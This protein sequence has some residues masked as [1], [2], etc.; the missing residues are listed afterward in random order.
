MK[1]PWS[2]RSEEPEPEPEPE[3][4]TEQ[5]S[6]LF[7]TQDLDL[8]EQIVATSNVMAVRDAINVFLVV[9]RDHRED[10]HDCPPYCVPTQLAYFLQVMDGN[11]LRMM[12]TVVLK[13]M[14]ETYLRQMENLEGQ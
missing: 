10:G 5:P 4:A 2:R 11:D 12:L 6:S 7:R 1:W 13:D 8:E 3:P 14:V 9:I